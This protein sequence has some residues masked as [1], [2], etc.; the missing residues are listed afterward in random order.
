MSGAFGTQWPL[1]MMW[2]AYFGLHSALA[3]RGCKAALTARWPH[4]SA[5]YRLF[6]NLLAVLTLLPI[7]FWLWAYPGPG[8]WRW[9]GAGAWVANGLAGMALWG[10]VLSSRHYDMRAFLGTRAAL[11]SSA[12]LR[13]SPWHHHVRHPWYSLGLVVLWTRDMDV[14]MLVS[15]LMIT[16]Y[17]VIGSR[18]EEEKLIAEFG[19]TYRR[20][21]QC[22]PALVPW[23][24]KS[25]DAESAKRLL[26]E[27]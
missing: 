27:P 15:A 1:V 6:Y 25:L 17:L 8:L 16:A 18:L 12:A 3:S 7:G 4:A 26:G 11:E 23:P 20:Y 21:R 9:S 14:A 5:R 13:I 10:V 19:D 2:L 22:V 24:G